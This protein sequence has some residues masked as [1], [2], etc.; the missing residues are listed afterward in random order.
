MI[1]TFRKGVWL[2]CAE[3]GLHQAGHEAQSFLHLCC[4]LVVGLGEALQ[5]ATCWTDGLWRG[6]LS[7]A[8]S[9]QQHS[10][11]SPQHDPTPHPL[12][13][14]HPTDQRSGGFSSW[15]ELCLQVYKQKTASS[16]ISA[17]LE[18]GEKPTDILQALTHSNSSLTASAELTSFLSD[19]G[20][21]HPKSARETI[22]HRPASQDLQAELGP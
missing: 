5:G 12:T 13:Q 9:Q 14:A 1:P 11:S 22:P 2:D 21:T 16:Y 19:C 18:T 6:R 20:V 10:Y 15:S 7:Q 8:E 17:E 3:K 4:V